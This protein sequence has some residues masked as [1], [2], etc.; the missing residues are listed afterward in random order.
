MPLLEWDPGA[1]GKDG[2]TALQAARGKPAIRRALAQG[3]SDGANALWLACRLGDEVVAREALAQGADALQFGPPPA[4]LLQ[5]PRTGLAVSAVPCSPGAG[6][7]PWQEACTRGHAA[8]VREMLEDARLALDADAALD[9][10]DSGSWPLR[11]ACER[12]HA[13]VL[14]A[15]LA[16]R[17]TLAVSRA[18]AQGDSCAT[19]C[20]A[21]GATLP[22]ALAPPP[23]PSL[24]EAVGAAD[25]APRPPVPRAN[26]Q[27][28]RPPPCAGAAPR[29]CA[30]PLSLS[31]SARRRA[32]CSSRSLRPLPRVNAGRGSCVPSPGAA[33]RPNA[34]T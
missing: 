26:D 23:R 2:E 25:T 10:A 32:V 27:R 4:P 7:T 6:T 18:D 19:L 29:G 14:R 28:R 15:L 21:Q 1:R 5:P 12:G 20:A 33:G 17:T 8:C 9:P 30:P 31:P 3:G 13:A 24:H 22:C 16:G 34:G 11:A